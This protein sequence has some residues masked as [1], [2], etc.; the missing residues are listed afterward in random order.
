MDVEVVLLTELS[1]AQPVHG[2]EEAPHRR[3]WAEVEAPDQRDHHPPTDAPL[4]QID[5]HLNSGEIP[6]EG[7][8]HGHV[9][10]GLAQP[11]APLQGWR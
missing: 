3:D 5:Q 6:G 10:Q 1:E 2:F 8:G 11:A 9:D 4:L 7:I